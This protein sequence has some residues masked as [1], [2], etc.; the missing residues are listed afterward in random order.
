MLRDSFESR[1]AQSQTKLIEFLQSDLDV[2]F[3]MLN[4]AELEDDQECYK[5]ALERA[6]VALDT[7]RGLEER[8][9][10]AGAFRD[11]RARAGELGA[12]LNGFFKATP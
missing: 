3:A 10:D 8:I 12:T 11:I 2:A 4:A 1:H 9:E 6:R 5:S 7:I